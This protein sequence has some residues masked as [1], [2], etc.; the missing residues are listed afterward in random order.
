MDPARRPATDRRHPR[1]GHR[2]RGLQPAP[3]PR[4]HREP[5]R[6]PR[7]V[8]PRAR[9]ISTASRSATRCSACRAAPGWAALGHFTGA[10]VAPPQTWDEPAA[11]R[12]RFGVRPSSHPDSVRARCVMVIGRD[13]TPSAG[14]AWPT[15]GSSTT[16]RRKGW[17]RTALRRVFG[18]PTPPATF[19]RAELL[20][21]LW[22]SDVID[23][24]DGGRRG[25][26]LPKAAALP[27]CTRRSASSKPAVTGFGSDRCRGRAAFG[28]VLTWNEVRRRARQGRFR[29]RIEPELAAWM[30][31]GMLARWLVG[32]FPPIEELAA[33][34]CRA[35]R[36]PVA[37]ALARGA[38][39]PWRPQ[40]VGGVMASTPR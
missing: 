2:R 6:R 29:R 36:P 27:S 33:Q 26:S 24:A 3:H 7:R 16:R 1:R 37:A 19:P 5:P 11:E 28:R 15:A 14:S 23:E 18:L 12:G 30:D 39:E 4:P 13:G 10:W 40:R 9:P 31:E 38:T 22:L 32:G 21:S 17:P 25:R 8:P 35:L 34:A 20:T